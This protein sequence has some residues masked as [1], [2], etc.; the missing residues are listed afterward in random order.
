MPEF[1]RENRRRGEGIGLGVEGDLVEIEEAV[2]ARES[3]IGMGKTRRGEE[4]HKRCVK[5]TTTDVKAGEHIIRVRTDMLWRDKRFRQGR[6]VIH[7]DVN[8]G[9]IRK[10]EGVET[11]TRTDHV[12]SSCI[13][14]RE[15]ERSGERCVMVEERKMWSSGDIGTHVALWSGGRGG[16]PTCMKDRNEVAVMLS[17]GRVRG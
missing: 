6:A 12:M 5:M 13:S 9:V 16:D 2:G 8:A 7:G 4:P 10:T 1:R 14:T 17:S 3:S 11:S 15:I